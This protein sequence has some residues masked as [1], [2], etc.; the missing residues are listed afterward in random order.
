MGA[1]VMTNLDLFE[2]DVEQRAREARDAG[3]R[4]AIDHANAVDPVG[5]QRAFAHVASKVALMQSG[6][7]TT[8]EN[9]RILAE[10]LGLPSPADK[11]AWG[12]VMVR[13]AKAG[14]LRR[15]G[16]TTSIDPKGHC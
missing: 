7:S 1:D 10:S 5:E 2:S 6:G 16:W 14:L 11:R 13:A 9:I 12:A 15:N 3:I 4:A 8:G